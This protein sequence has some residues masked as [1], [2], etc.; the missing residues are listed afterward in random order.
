MVREKQ[1]CESNDDNI[2]MFLLVFISHKQSSL[3]LSPV[4]DKLPVFTGFA[5]IHISF[6][7]HTNNLVINQN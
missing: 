2:W 6:K 7:M 5:L 1:V 3:A 4:T